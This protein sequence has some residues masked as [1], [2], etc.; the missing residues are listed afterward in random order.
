M[1]LSHNTAARPHVTNAS[2]ST[3]TSP[4]VATVDSARLVTV[5]TSALDGT[6][7][8]VSAN[9]SH[10]AV[11]LSSAAETALI[12]SLSSQSHGIPSLCQSVALTIAVITLVV[13]GVFASVTLSLP[14]CSCHCLSTPLL[15]KSRHL[16]FTGSHCL[17]AVFVSSV[18]LHFFQSA[19]EW[20]Y[21]GLVVEFAASVLAWSRPWSVTLVFIYWLSFA[22]GR[23]VC[24]VLIARVRPWL[25]MISGV[26]LGLVSSLVMLAGSLQYSTGAEVDALMWLSSA[27]LGLSTSV[28]LPTSY[29]YIP[30]STSLSVAV[31]VGASLGEASVPCLAA[32]L[33]DVY[34]NTNYIIKAVTAAAGGALVSTIL[35][36]YAI[37][38]SS[39][40]T[41]T[42][43]SRQFHLVDSSGVDELDSAM[44]DTV[45]EAEDTELLS[46][47]ACV[48]VETS[49]IINAPPSSPLKS[50]I[51]NISS[52]SKND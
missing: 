45:D 27:V 12:A 25:L 23:I 9:V 4:P 7:D 26:L 51:R 47:A 44:N 49:L 46:Q 20:T 28:V 11:T 13:S 16:S 17:V 5:S 40:S 21:S 3:S 50:F 38:H 14:C 37:T 35:F 8:S 1:T 52:T 39:N 30:W 18:L 19:V 48:D 32:V 29:K 15:T 31:T 42:A 33:A 6:A 22:V 43:S 41:G 2:H 10:R 34:S 24:Y 36:K